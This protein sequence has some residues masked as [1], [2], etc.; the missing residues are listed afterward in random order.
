MLV[1][2][3]L[4]Y[5]ELKLIKK[6][7]YFL[8]FLVITSSATQAVVVNSFTAPLKGEWGGTNTTNISSFVTSNYHG[9]SVTVNVTNPNEDASINQ[10]SNDSF[11]HISL[12]ANG[13]YGKIVSRANGIN[14]SIELL[15]NSS[16]SAGSAG[17][18]VGVRGYT[19]SINAVANLNLKGTTVN[20]LGNLLVNGL[21]IS[22]GSVS[23]NVVTQNYHKIFNNTAFSSDGSSATHFNNSASFTDARSSWNV[24][25]M[26]SGAHN[27]S[28]IFLDNTAGVLQ[29]N[30]LIYA[31]DPL[32]AAQISIKTADELGIINLATTQLNLVA[33]GSSSLIAINSDNSITLNAQTISNVASNKVNMVTKQINMTS[34]TMNVKSIFFRVSTSNQIGTSTANSFKSVSIGYDYGDSTSPST[35]HAA[36]A[37][38]N[39]EYWN[40][41]AQKKFTNAVELNTYT[42]VTVNASSYTGNGKIFLIANDTRGGIITRSKTLNMYTSTYNADS[43]PLA[44]SA[45]IHSSDIGLYSRNLLMQSSTINMNGSVFVNGVPISGGP[46]P[47]NVVT[48]NY[49][50]LVNINATNG[51]K[52]VAFNNEFVN[53]VS[54]ITL[55]VSAADDRTYTSGISLRSDTLPSQSNVHIYASD[56]LNPP[57]ITLSTD[58]GDTIVDSNLI[59]LN[60]PGFGAFIGINSSDQLRIQAASMN[61]I[62]TVKVNG[63]PISGS[64]LPNTVVTDNYHR[65]I[66]FNTASITMNAT[67]KLTETAATIN[68]LAS[69]GPGT[70]RINIIADDVLGS[71]F[72]GASGPIGSVQTVVPG[73]AGIIEQLALGTPGGGYPGGHIK[74]QGYTTSINASSTLDLIAPNI[75]LNGSVLVNGSPI[76]SGVLSS[77][78]VTD[79]YHNNLNFNTTSITMNATAGTFISGAYL[80]VSANQFIADSDSSQLYS[81]TMLISANSGRITGT[82]L[83]IDA[84]EMNL[85]SEK[86]KIQTAGINNEILIKSASM[87]L[88]G[89]VKVNGSPIISYTSSNGVS[90]NGSVISLSSPFR[91]LNGNVGIGITSPTQKLDV[92]GNIRAKGVN[93]TTIS[94]QSAH[95]SI[96]SEYTDDVNGSSLIGAI[97]QSSSEGI[98]MEKYGSNSG[99]SQYGI[100]MDNGSQISCTSDAPTYNL[101]IKTQGTNSPIYFASGSSSIAITVSPNSSV[102][103]GTTRPKSKLDVNG[104]ISSTGN[105]NNGSVISNVNVFTSTGGY[106]V[107]TND[108]TVIINKATGAATSVTLPSSPIKGRTICVIDGKGDALV[109]N[110]TISPSSGTINGA[111]TYVISANYGAANLV[112]NGTEWNVF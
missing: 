85:D 66:N 37:S 112:Y 109:N 12:N 70:G 28:G 100:S 43:A 52:W 92:S 96:T 75:N 26:A 88:V 23:S 98:F 56:L 48:N 16:P 81:R 6:I 36:I 72:I 11:G 64:A 38:M 102:G 54:V 90:I 18:A 40:S 83:N 45:N 44:G 94:S 30:V 13:R 22:G 51:A 19:T 84:Q 15:S 69:N 99:L 3:G 73:K 89:T 5:K 7:I 41:V 57:K 31:N 34:T 68:I 8:A 111:S 33:T 108:Y 86:I 93:F 78:V 20:I 53:D 97:S 77:N 62:G 104:N 76:P 27:K 60:A 61:L 105:I 101:I 4:S 2:H 35:T 46:L 110:I 79:N 91:V 47:S 58:F 9:K 63:L 21:P 74:V 42:G 95:P 25:Y 103:I 55:N 32:D 82:T 14:G 49:H 67:G 59:H 10:F 24:E 80:F 50:S 29:D 39:V 87:N 107:G 17:G 65:N 106:S 1:A 71:V